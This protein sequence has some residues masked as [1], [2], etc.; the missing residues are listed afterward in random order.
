MA[1]DK[2][3]KVRILT[4]VEFDGEKLKADSVVVLDA[5]DAKDLIGTGWADD[6]PDA[7]AYAESLAA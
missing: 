3:V 1:K 5:K 7:V 6:N 2:T 4:N